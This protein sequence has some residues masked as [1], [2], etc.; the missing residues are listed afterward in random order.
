MKEYVKPE[1]EILDLEIDEI[2]SADQDIDGSMGTGEEIE[3]DI[4]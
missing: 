2:I 4:E 1:I 3:D